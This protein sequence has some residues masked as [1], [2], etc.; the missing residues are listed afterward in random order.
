M[1]ILLGKVSRSLKKILCAAQINLFQDKRNLDLQNSIAYSPQSTL[2]DD[3][4]FHIEFNAENT[5][6]N[7]IPD[8]SSANSNNWVQVAKVDYQKIR[9]IA[10][11][12]KNVK[13]AFY[14]KIPESL[15]IKKPKLGLFGLNDEPS[16]ITDPIIL[17]NDLPDAI[18]DQTLNRLYFRHINKLTNIF[19]GIDQLFREAT[20]QEVSNFVN[21][22]IFRTDNGFDINK[23]SIPVRKKIALVQDKYANF[24]TEQQFEFIANVKE[25]LPEIN[26]D[27]SKFHIKNNED[28]RDLADA[29]DLKFHN[30]PIT[31]EPRRTQSY[32][33]L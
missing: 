6:N 22:T 17:I 11:I 25:F 1:D 13:R 3:Q 23:V 27:N 32:R 19:L 10:L 26:F 5:I 15:L 8:C 14:Q 9:Y 28:A 33:S 4:W 18:Y 31:N 12:D 24:T 29:L 20:E 21:S 7:P 16:I 2:D 30:T